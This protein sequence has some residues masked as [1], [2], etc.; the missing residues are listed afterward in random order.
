MFQIDQMLWRV[1]DMKEIRY[2]CNS[3]VS[4]ENNTLGI[5]EKIIDKLDGQQITKILISML[6]FG[7]ICY[8]T[9]KCGSEGT[10]SLFS[11][12]DRNEDVAA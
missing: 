2:N 9:S 6:K 3:N 5:I 11:D 1:R 7:T 8:V 10:K 12:F 4:S